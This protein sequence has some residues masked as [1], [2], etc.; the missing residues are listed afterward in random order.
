MHSRTFKGHRRQ[1]QLDQYA[2]CNRR[3]LTES[4]A[5][6]W[7]ALRGRKMGVQFRRQA[8]LCGRYIADFLAPAVRLVVEVDGGS[9]MGRK[10]QDTKRDAH[11]QLCGYRVLRVDAAVVLCDLPVAL[12]LIRSSLA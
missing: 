5:R 8:P 11:L 1:V 10:H 9:H 7:D 3:A 2:W 4:E 12:A 6:L